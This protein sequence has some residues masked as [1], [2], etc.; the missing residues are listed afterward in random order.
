MVERSGN[1]DGYKMAIYFQDFLCKILSIFKIMNGR[2]LL[3]V[4]NLLGNNFTE[5]FY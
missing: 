2:L 5:S 4:Q 3:C 1:T